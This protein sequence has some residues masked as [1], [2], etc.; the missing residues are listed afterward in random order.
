M[1]SGSDWGSW[2]RYYRSRSDNNRGG[3]DNRCDGYRSR[4]DNWCG[5][6]N[7]RGSNG[8]RCLDRRSFNNRSGCRFCGR[9][10]GSSSSARSIANVRENS[11]DGHGLILLDEDC[12]DDA[13]DWRR[14]LS[15]DLVGRNLK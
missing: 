15:V 9:G 3:S 12:F 1:V 14:N 4:G 2:G 13:G 7:D 11:A 8:S 6:D 5:S 10:S